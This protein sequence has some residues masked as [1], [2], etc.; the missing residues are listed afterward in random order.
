MNRTLKAILIG[1]IT[2][3]IAAYLIKKFVDKPPAK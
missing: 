1:A 2:S 3:V